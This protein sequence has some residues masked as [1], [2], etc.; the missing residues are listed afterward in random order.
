MVCIYLDNSATTPILPE[1]RRAMIPFLESQFG[2]PSSA[3]RLGIQAERALEKARGE[4]ASCLGVDASRIIFTSGGSESNNMAIWGI[5]RRWAPKGGRKIITTA[6]EH[7]SVLE[8]CRRLEQLDY[9]VEYLPA[10]PEGRVDPNDLAAALSPD[11]LLVSIMHV[12]NETGA[13][14]PL[15]E[16]AEVVGRHNLRQRS[17]SR[18][19]YLHV[20]AVQ[21]FTKLP[22]P[23]E[24]V[25]LL[26]VSGHKIGA[27]KGVG[28]LYLAEGVQIE[29]LIYG[30]GQE[31]GLRSGT[32]NVAGI[33]AMGTA[34]QLAAG[35][36]EQRREA[37]QR[38]RGEFLRRVQSKVPE[39][40]ING[41]QREVSPYICSLAFPPIP[42]EVLIHSLE[43]Q[44]V[45]VSTG[46]ACSSRRK[47]HSHVLASMGVPQRVADSTI[48]VSMGP[49]TSEAE[50]LQAADILTTVVLELK[51]LYR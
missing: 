17:A 3:H 31:A 15:A 16:I 7:P 21:S 45:Y 2:N 27:P 30:G 51:D 24:G 4:V 18:R 46:A 6:I 20:D 11:V 9:E 22:V 41:P 34:A 37:I 32:E 25:D 44:G 1:V 38:M 35:Q 33:V 5:C 13:V 23:I 49:S 10:D 40:V 28:A 19:A 26:T 12:N 8:A 48:R 36:V 50:L 42:G 14:L 39:V 43:E 29:P 47:K